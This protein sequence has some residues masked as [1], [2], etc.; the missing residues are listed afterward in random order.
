MIM[1]K[2]IFTKEK[3]K[4]I[5]LF[6][7]AVGV[8]AWA[9]INFTTMNYVAASMVVAGGLALSLYAGVEILRL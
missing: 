2:N 1:A 7:V 9:Y 3:M 6:V 5:A 4:Y 8:T